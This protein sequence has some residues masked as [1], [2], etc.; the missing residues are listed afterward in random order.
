MST[1]HV[2]PRIFITLAGAI[3]G[4]AA[5]VCF[6]ALRITGKPQEFRSLAKLVAGGQILFNDSPDWREQRQDF[7]GTIIETVESAEMKRRALERVRAL[8]PDLIEV[9]VAIR[10]TQLK[11]T[12]IFNILATG[13]EPKYTRAFLDAL[14]DEFIA[15]R[16]RIR[17]QG[18]QAGNT[19]EGI[20]HD[21][22]AIQE[23]ASIAVE[24]VEDWTLPIAAGV[25]GGGLL[26]A[27]LG[28]L[29]SL[30][31]VRPASPPERTMA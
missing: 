19:S 3:I 6:P 15:F 21:Y 22:L 28:L 20:A 10:V 16:Q 11:D 5:G 26:G 7:Y 14:L 29:L 30:V 25:I 24:I 8:E 17:Q 4:V 27:M 31:F 18:E 2:L 12:A 1:S 9:D 23:R 13:S